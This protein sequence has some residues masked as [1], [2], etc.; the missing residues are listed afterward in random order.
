MKLTRASSCAHCTCEN[1]DSLKV[2][3]MQY[4]ITS[5]YKM[6]ETV[7]RASGEVLSSEAA[8]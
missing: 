5:V 1:V 8:F 2:C 7:S 4:Y 6:Y 3:R